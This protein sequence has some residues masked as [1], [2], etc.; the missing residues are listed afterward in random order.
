MT[1][2]AFVSIKPSPKQ[3]ANA[4]K[5]KQANQLVREYCSDD[6]RLDFIDVWTPM[7]G[8]DG[9]PKPELYVAINCN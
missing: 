2:I 8:A 5:I 4:A 3:W 1:R 9:K 6:M 7:L